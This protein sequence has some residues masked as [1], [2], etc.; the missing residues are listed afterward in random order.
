MKKLLITGLTAFVFFFVSERIFSQSDSPVFET[1]SIEDGLPENSVLSMLQDYLGYM[2]FGT[3]N[4]LVKYDGYT[5]TVYKPD[6]ADNKSVSGT[7]IVVLFEDSRKN[8]WVGTEEGLNRFNRADESF[9]RYQSDP[10]DSSSISCNV[11]HTIYEDRLGRFWVGTLCG[12]NLFDRDNEK[13]TRFYFTEPDLKTVSRVPGDQYSLAITA[14]TEVSNSEELLLGTG[15]KGLWRF[16]ISRKSISKYDI[17]ISPDKIGWV[18]NFYRARD[19]K[20]W[21]GSNN[22]LSVLDPVS[23][24]FKS[25][26]DFPDKVEGKYFEAEVPMSSVLEDQFGNIAAG[27]Y[28]GEE[29]LIYLD[30][31]TGIVN[32][33]KFISNIPQNTMLNKLHSVYEDRSGILWIGTW[34]TGVKK[35]KRYENAFSVQ[36]SNA[37]DLNSLSSPTV[38]AL[39]C[40]PKGYT[41]YCTSKGLDKYDQRT[42]RY[43]HYLQN[44]KCI[45]DFMV[46]AMLLDKSGYLWLGTSNC[47]LIRFNP[48]TASYSYYLNDP[49]KMNLINKTVLYL[50]QD[51]LGYI[52]IGTRDYGLYKYEPE[53]TSLIQY[54]HDPNDSLSL[55]QDE[56]LSL[57][58]DH[59]GVL[60]VGTNLG[61]LNKF[62]RETGKF[63]YAGFKNCLSLYEDSENRM[64]VSELFS[65][66]SLFDREKLKAA[67]N[68]SQNNGLAANAGIGIIEDND[69]NLWFINEMGISRV[70]PKNKAVNNFPVINIYSNVFNFFTPNCTGKGTDG[71]L[72]INTGKGLVILNPASIMDD[73]TP[74]RVV[75]SNLSL[76][77]RA[78]EK[79]DYNGFIPETKE[80]TLPYDQ[81]DLR[82]DYVG[83]QFN[84]PAKNTYKY[85]LENFD[86]DWVDAG[87]QRNATYTNL[88]PG[89]YNF[90]VKAANRDGVWSPKDASIKIIILPPWWKTTAAYILYILF[91]TGLIFLTWKLQMKRIRIKQQYEMSRFEAEKLHEVD[92]IKSRFFTNISHEFRTPLTL[93]LG[94]VKQLADKTADEKSKEVLR[95]VH[96]NAE[97][98]LALVNQLLDI[99]K[100]ESGNMKIHAAEHD[101]AA[102]I[103]AITLSFTS[104]AERK[105]IK[106]S[107][108]SRPDEIRA[109]I[110]KEKFENIINNLLS[111]AFKFTPEGGS[112]EVMIDSQAELV[113]ASETN[114]IPK[115]VRDDNFVGS[116]VRDDNFAEITSPDDNIIRIT[117][118]DTGM[119]IP[120]EK[121]PRIFDRFYQV[122][123]SHRREHEG[124]GIGLALTKELVELHKGMIEVESTEGKGT[125]FTIRIPTGKGHLQAEEIGKEELAKDTDRGAVKATGRP[126][127]DEA[128]QY[129]GRLETAAELSG[130][131]SSHLLLIVED[132]NDVRK[133]IKD[134][135]TDDY[136]IIEASDGVDGCD[137]ALSEIPELIISDVM[138]P[139]M[140]GFELCRKL[141]TDERTSHIPIILLTA[142]AASEDK[143]EGYETGADEY[144]MKPFNSNELKARIKN[145]IEQRKRIHEHFR[146]NGL[147]EIDETRITSI[148]KK[149][150]QNTFCLINDNISDDS[151][152]VERLAEGLSI[153]RSVLH[154]KVVSLTGEPPV[155]LIKTIRMTRAAELIR[156]KTGNISE[157]ALEVGFKNPAYFSEC[158][159]KH[160][161]IS[162]SQYSHSFHQ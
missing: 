3:Q 108:S 81:N 51:H 69:K 36:Q 40:D 117:I 120:E 105:R 16:D 139:K 62:N 101:A 162:P 158:F 10:D 152:S 52:W 22:I 64:W 99:S 42:H 87:T 126:V 107:F 70:N 103:R 115:Q 100:I 45:T 154:K 129:N 9:I 133:Y 151:F 148:D 88:N 84:E 143:I 142:K 106:L 90:R 8:L 14:I 79:L 114:K 159:K 17:N 130:N 38:N 24:E 1:I 54:K 96:R 104:Y 149:F 116:N 78:D 27:F 57:L 82:F 93:I 160:F 97:K 39:I 7:R 50:L 161:R 6:A 37:S 86:E 35:W 153:S 32:K 92:G 75:I 155:E 77:N 33:Y 135:L 76:F 85:I 59:N 13:F 118:R 58:E 102:L 74:P 43:T 5:M 113:S 61:G 28:D 109:Y 46:Y 83:L 26:Y 137:R 73:P 132:N 12:L 121:L 49:D 128:L 71:M 119:G 138:M 141:K 18:Q 136:K 23:R 98:L 122:D 134:N 72:Y 2:W 4:G 30:P 80:V 53:N 55:S 127:I 31:R 47:G 34:S 11:V 124:T 146:Q 66:L 89:E 147:I 29:G 44:E 48:E 145:L 15:L 95:V 41:W 65:G 156:L 56:V 21:I 110:D 68:F 150:L 112:I 19:G 144:I 25:Y 140:D 91:I 63:T 111:N 94:P 67:D 60:W 125:L 20:I 131:G 157:I 123:G